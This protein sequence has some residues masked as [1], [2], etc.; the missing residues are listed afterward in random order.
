MDLAASSSGSSDSES[1]S[2]SDADDS[3]YDA[4]GD[5][6]G[7]RAGTDVRAAAVK[8]E[9]DAG[10]VP[11]AASAGP[12]P[13]ADRSRGRSSGRDAPAEVIEISDTSSDEEVGG[14][15][16]VEEGVA[17][18]KRMRQRGELTT[19]LADLRGLRAT[20]ETPSSESPGWSR[21]VGWSTSFLKQAVAVGCSFSPR[22]QPPPPPA[23]TP[24]GDDTSPQLLRIRA[25]LLRLASALELPPNPLDDLTDRM[26]GEEAVA[27]LTGRK[28]RRSRLR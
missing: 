11:R 1:S 6:D 10:R 15:D 24:V 26:G 27:E 3:D 25:M 14:R 16:A 20:S 5:S 22:A 18:R 23:P 21:L 4:S 28:V 12:A 17:D 8:P 2:S 9:A 13:P 19:E 7:G